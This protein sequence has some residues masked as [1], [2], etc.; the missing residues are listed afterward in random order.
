MHKYVGI[1]SVLSISRDG[2]IKRAQRWTDRSIAYNQKA[3]ASDYN[4][5]YARDYRTDCSGYVTM[6]WNLNCCCCYNTKNL[7]TIAKEIKKD[8]LKAGDILLR[9]NKHTLIFWEWVD[10]GKTKYRGFEMD[11][12]HAK[13]VEY[14]YPYKGTSGKFYKPYRYNFITD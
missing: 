10:H 2:V 4:D 14:P 1:V 9:K 3:S 12:P 6:A 8:E 11:E 7:H 5:H 13:V